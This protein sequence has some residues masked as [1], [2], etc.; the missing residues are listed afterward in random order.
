MRTTEKKGVFQTEIFKTVK[1]FND[2]Y[3]KCI[4]DHFLPCLL[5]YSCIYLVPGTRLKP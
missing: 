5:F 2:E 3:L 1:F 4:T